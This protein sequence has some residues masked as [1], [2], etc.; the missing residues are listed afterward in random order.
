MKKKK[1]KK[2]L[3]VQK[4]LHGKIWWPPTRSA[5]SKCSTSLQAVV[6]LAPCMAMLAGQDAHG[7]LVRL[8]GLRPDPQQLPVN[9]ALGQTGPVAVVQLQLE[10]LDGKSSH[11]FRHDFFFVPNVA[12]VATFQYAA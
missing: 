12:F 5:Q 11:L 10:K 3:Q 8:P 2:A 4:K 6:R 9:L 1:K 7:L